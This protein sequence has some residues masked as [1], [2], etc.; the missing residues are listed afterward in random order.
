M[1]EM[2]MD[3]Y[4]YYAATLLPSLLMWTNTE[5]LTQEEKAVYDIL[6]EWNY[7]MDAEEMGPSI[8][9][10]W[11]GNF[12]RAVL[13]DE[14]ET[15]EAILRYPPRDMFV[16]VVKNDEDFVFIDNVDTETQESRQ[17]IT[18][19]S[20]QETVSELTEA[21][22]ELGDRWLWGNAINNDVNHL[23]NIPGMGAT[24]LFSS[25]SSE[26]VN[27]T[28]G[29]HGPS[30]RMVVE[31]GPEVKGWGVYPGGP[32]GNPGSPNYDTMIEPW[33]TGQLFELN[34]MKN[35]PAEFLYSI[36]LTGGE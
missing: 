18:T 9:R 21:W 14:F 28:R 2:Q 26:S 35:E 29:T 1:Q 8:F 32:S 31:L 13:G 33:R 4:S 7:Y 10:Q 15:T 16:E 36:E 22:G 11:A 6:A 3:D 17:N 24:D 12:Y 20:F 30:W 25:G 19:A 27:A 23:A 5:K 34:F